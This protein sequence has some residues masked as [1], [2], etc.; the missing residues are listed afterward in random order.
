[1]LDA[2]LRARRAGLGVSVID[3]YGVCTRMDPQLIM[4]NA[5]GIWRQMEY[6]ANFYLI[7]IRSES[8][9]TAESKSEYHQ[10]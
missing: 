7:V 2:R 8:L 9:K 3:A 5:K 1:M 4:V 6:V 10:S